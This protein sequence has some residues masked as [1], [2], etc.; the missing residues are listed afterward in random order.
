MFKGVWDWFIMPLLYSYKIFMIRVHELLKI[1]EI[2]VKNDKKK[3]EKKNDPF[4]KRKNYWYQ[5]KSERVHVKMKTKKKEKVK[6]GS[7]K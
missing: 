4:R 3:K 7:A 5:I 1:E 2:K 6:R